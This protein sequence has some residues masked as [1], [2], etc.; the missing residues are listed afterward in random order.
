MAYLGT[1]A[2]VSQMWNTQ[3]HK[4]KCSTMLRNNNCTDDNNTEKNEAEVAEEVQVVKMENVVEKT[5]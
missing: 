1:F 2:S 3:G 4:E 5:R